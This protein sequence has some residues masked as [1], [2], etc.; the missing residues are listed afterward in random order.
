MIRVGGWR[1]AAG[2]VALPRARARDLAVTSYGDG[3]GHKLTQRERWGNSGE[4]SRGL[5]WSDWCC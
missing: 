2:D 3:L 5:R 1:G 4:A